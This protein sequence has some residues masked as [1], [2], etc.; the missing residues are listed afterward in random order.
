MQIKVIKIPK[1]IVPSG[2]HYSEFKTTVFDFLLSNPKNISRIGVCSAHGDDICLYMMCRWLIEEGGF[3]AQSFKQQIQAVHGLSFRK[4]KYLISLQSLYGEML[5]DN[6]TLQYFSEKLIDQN[7]IQTQKQSEDKIVEPVQKHEIPVSVDMIRVEFDESRLKLNTKEI[8]P[9]IKSVGVALDPIDE[10]NIKKDV[11]SNL[12]VK[13]ERLNFDR[14]SLKDIANEKD[15]FWI[16]EDAKGVHV[17]LLFKLSCCFIIGEQNWVRKVNLYMPPLNSSNETMLYSIFE[18]IIW[19]DPS[20]NKLQIMFV[21]IINNEASSTMSLPFAER[22]NLIDQILANRQRKIDENQFVHISNDFDVRIRKYCR[23]KYLDFLKQNFEV[24]D[25]S[26][27]FKSKDGRY[28]STE[29]L[30]DENNPLI[31]TVELNILLGTFYGVDND[32]KQFVIF[33]HPTKE[34]A[35]YNE[36]LIDIIYNRMTNKWEMLS[37]SSSKRAMDGDH[38]TNTILETRKPPL[39]FDMLKRKI[40]KI[41][42]K[43]QYVQE[44]LERAKMKS[45]AK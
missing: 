31:I 38:L 15:I 19:H 45:Y 32:E 40:D 11:E 18:G 44:E 22:A 37:L 6:L 39:N 41:L 35:K 1:G 2:A 10:A 29:Y 8:D 14:Y 21:D 13:K 12:T 43:P 36:C 25:S 23:L 30:Y 16:M 34:F 17:Y 4:P 5:V 42:L 9:L 7:L 3:T 26:I 33:D 20:K 24:Q 28:G 27:L